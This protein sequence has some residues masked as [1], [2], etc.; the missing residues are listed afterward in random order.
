MES[1]KGKYRPQYSG[2]HVC[3]PYSL[4]HWCHAMLCVY[5]MCELLPLRMPPQYLQA[6]VVMVRTLPPATWKLYMRICATPAVHT[7]HICTTTVIHAHLS[8]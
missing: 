7:K 6:L 1:S 8:T 5:P 2:P 3:W 4:L